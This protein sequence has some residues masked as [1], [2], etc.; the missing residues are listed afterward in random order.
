MRNCGFKAFAL[1]LVAALFL[2]GGQAMAADAKFPDGPINFIVAYGPGGANDICARMLAP[3][4]EK[5][6][7]VPVTVTNIPGGGGWIGYDA[8]LNAA[9]DGQTI[10]MLSC[11]AVIS[12]YVNPETGR[13]NT[14]R[15]FAPLINF[16]NDYQVICCRP[17][18]TR[19]KTFKELVEYSKNNEILISGTAGAGSDGMLIAKL[20]SIEGAQFVHLATNGASESLTNLYGKH[21]DICSIDI[22]ETTAPLKAGQVKVLAVAASKRVPQNPDIPTIKEECGVE[23]VN[24][25]GRGI[26]TS[27]KVPAE[28][29]AVLIDALTKAFQNPE[30]Q[31]ALAGQ[32]IAVEIMDA[33]AY[34]EYLDRTEQELK[35][36]GPKYFGWELD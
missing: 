13:T 29:Q 36:I 1:A 27:V 35:E 11:P 20:N 19:F 18:E 3:E 31:K 21:S 2:A 22:S 33:K 23:I 32:G 28:K 4:L 26:A 16:A 5:I 7:G 14:Y 24:F 10:G 17:D 9:P 34:T 30:L 6:L 15:D 25:S 12:G 8:I